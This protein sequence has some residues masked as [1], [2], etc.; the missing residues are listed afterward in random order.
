MEIEISTPTVDIWF[1]ICLA[2]DTVET[3][4]VKP[5]FYLGLEI[6]G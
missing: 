6:I 4:Q 5:V 1:K 2:V 3:C